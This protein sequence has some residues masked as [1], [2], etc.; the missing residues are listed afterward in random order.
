MRTSRHETVMPVDADIVSFG[1]IALARIVLYAEDG[2]NT[3]AMY[4]FELKGVGA[5]G[6]RPPDWAF[7]LAERLG[8]FKARRLT[9]EEIVERTT[10][11]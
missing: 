11:R 2:Q 6:V 1:P 10:T 3:H 7:E 4:W 5:V 8:V 9:S